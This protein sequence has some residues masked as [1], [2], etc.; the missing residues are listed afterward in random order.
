MDS[1]IPAND[2]NKKFPELKTSSNFLHMHSRPESPNLRGIKRF[3]E[4]IKEKANKPSSKEPAFNNAFYEEEQREEVI[5]HKFRIPIG[6]TEGTWSERVLEKERKLRREETKISHE[7]LKMIEKRTRYMDKGMISPSTKARNMLEPVVVPR[8]SSK[9]DIILIEDR[10]HVPS[11]ENSNKNEKTTPK[12]LM[13][14]SV[15]RKDLTPFNNMP[16]TRS[17]L[18]RQTISPLKIN[19]N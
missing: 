1:L 4:L 6:R 2:F 17:P 3:D 19:Y 14:R 13:P 16:S 10:G 8:S 11:S 9:K 12:R 5:M 15:S 7:R 18:H